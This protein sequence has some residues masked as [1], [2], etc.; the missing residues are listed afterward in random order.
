MPNSSPSDKRNQVCTEPISRDESPR[1]G[2]AKQW[3]KSMHPQ[4][5]Y[6]ISLSNVKCEN[7]G[8]VSTVI[9]N[10]Y[11]LSMSLSVYLGNEKA[12]KYLHLLATKI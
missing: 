10:D 2:K 8:N 3:I 1:R 11:L 12:E 9:C 6:L 4:A 7:V 5:S